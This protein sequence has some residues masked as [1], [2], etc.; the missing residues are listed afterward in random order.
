MYIFAIWLILLLLGTPVFI[1]LGLASVIYLLI[2]EMPLYIV[3]Q[4][5]FGALDSFILL[6]VPFY[7]MAGEVMNVGGVTRRLF[8]FVENALGFVPGALGHANVV[9]NMI[10][11]GMSGSAVAD[12]GG[13]GKIEIEAMTKAG[14]DRKFSAGLS[15]AA[16]IMGPIIPPSIPFVVYS[17][18]TGTSLGALFAAGVLP[19]ISIGIALMITVV[20]FSM[21]RHYPRKRWQGMASV[22]EIMESFISAAPA[23]VAPGIILGGIFS[24]L[25][26]PTEGSV[27]ASAYAF[28]LGLLVYRDLQLR[29]VVQIA[30]TTLKNTCVVFLIFCTSSLFS[31]ILTIERIPETMAQGLLSIS[32]NPTVVLMLINGFLLIVGMFVETLAAMIILVP[33]FY[34]SIVALGIHPVHFGLVVTVNLMIGILTPPFGTGL[35]VLQEVGKMTFEDAV[36]ACLPFIPPLLLVLLLITLFPEIVLYVP[37]LIGW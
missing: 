21:K 14:Y 34:P 6:A 20:I 22:V 24:G 3:A 25:F 11:S 10:L 26:T 12:L 23:L 17:A 27:V 33:F 18:I 5:M 29:D 13:L 1:S 19:G 32:Q 7:V 35:F 37:R 2:N 8:R 31:W 16:A 36:R 30:L 15:A 4:R 9:A 28:L